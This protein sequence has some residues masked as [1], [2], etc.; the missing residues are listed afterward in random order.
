MG[1]FNLRRGD[2][3]VSSDA[4]IH[5][6]GDVEGHY[7]GDRSESRRKG[8]WEDNIVRSARRKFIPA[9]KTPLD[10]GAETKI[11]DPFLLCDVKGNCY[12]RERKGPS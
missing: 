7:C 9:A 10:K 1:N 4:L 12:S 6:N 5:T 3:H 2:I 8:K 11:E